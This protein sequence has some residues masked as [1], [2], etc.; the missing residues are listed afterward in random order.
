M[1][2]ARRKATV[3]AGQTG[4]GVDTRALVR[5]GYSAEALAAAHHMEDCHPTVVTPQ[6]PRAG[7]PRPTQL[8][9]ILEMGGPSMKVTLAIDAESVVKSLSSKD[10]KKPTE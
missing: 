4:Q 9:D 7:P 6:E 2:T 10:Q 3:L 5:S 1:P 8:N